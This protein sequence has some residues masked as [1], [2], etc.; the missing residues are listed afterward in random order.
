VAL[1]CS[2]DCVPAVRPLETWSIAV[3]FSVVMMCP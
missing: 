2:P 1:A 3:S